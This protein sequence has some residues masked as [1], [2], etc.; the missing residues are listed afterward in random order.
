MSLDSEPTTEAGN[1]AVPG[2]RVPPLSQLHAVVGQGLDPGDV[3]KCR[4]QAVSVVSN[5]E[6]GSMSPSRDTRPVG[7]TYMLLS[8]AVE[9]WSLG[10]TFLEDRKRGSIPA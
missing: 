5:G 9:H 1:G 10:C 8:W 3:R 4:R 7:M 2:L 6:A